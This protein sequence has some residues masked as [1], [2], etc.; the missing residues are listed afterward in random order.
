[1]ATATAKRELRGTLPPRA[2]SAV[3]LQIFKTGQITASRCVAE[4]RLA[5]TSLHCGQPGCKCFILSCSQFG[6]AIGRSITP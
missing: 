6:A 3:G 4:G 2:D 5:L 1:M